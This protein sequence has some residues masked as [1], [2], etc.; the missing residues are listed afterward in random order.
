MLTS[1]KFDTLNTFKHTYEV[2]Y[3]I[4]PMMNSAKKK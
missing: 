2:N 1:P 3:I 4:L